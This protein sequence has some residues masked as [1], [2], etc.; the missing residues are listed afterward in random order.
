MYSV[1]L[2]DDENLMVQDLIRSIPWLENGFEVIGSNTNAITAITE[3]TDRKPDVVLTD[4][5]MPACDGIELIRR[6]KENGV[7][8][9]YIILSAYQDFEACRTLY[10]L[11]GFDY[12]L[13]PLERDAA[14]LVLEKLSR[15]LA[16]RHNQIP[17]VQFVPSQSSGFD[18]VVNYVTENFNNK[19]T[20]KDLADRFGLSQTYICDL[21]SK[22]YESTL[23]IF[24]TNLRMKEA[25]RLILQTDTPLKEICFFCGYQDYQRFCKV[26]KTHFGKIPSQYREDN[27]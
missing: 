18:N 12:I 26:F 3:I 13:K 8:A 15:R 27:G 25:S 9:E 1:Y 20:L 17:S 2:V 16:S 11:D 23:I 19:H 7:D 5:R 21:F 6:V 10:R 24:I 14:A 4:L 22:H